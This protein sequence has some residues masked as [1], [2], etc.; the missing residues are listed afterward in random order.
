MQTSG[1]IHLIYNTGTYI[2]LSCS[3]N[4]A[5]LTYDIFSLK[6]H[7]SIYC[8]SLL[9]GKN[10]LTGYSLDTIDVCRIKV[11]TL[12]IQFCRQEEVKAII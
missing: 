6:G 3:N 4:D 12:L 9:Y 8:L 5:K 2:F 11:A 10:A 1:D 7:T